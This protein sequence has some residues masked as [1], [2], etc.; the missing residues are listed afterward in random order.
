MEHVSSPARQKSSNFSP[1]ERLH[2]SRSVWAPIILSVALIACAHKQLMAQPSQI[3][4]PVDTRAQVKA[5]LGAYENAASPEQWRRLG[6]SAI[7]ILESIAVDTN[8]LPTSRA[9]SLDGLAALGT[10]ELTMRHLAGSAGERLIV[11]MSAVRGLGQVISESPLMDALRPLLQDSQAQLRGIAAETLSQTPAGCAEVKNMMAQENEAWRSRF[12]RR[13]AA[14]TASTGQSA[15][16]GPAVG[17]DPTARVV[18]YQIADPSGTIIYRYS[19]PSNIAKIEPSTYPG[20]F[21]VLLPN[22]PTVPFLSGAWTFNLLATKP[23]T[24][25]VQALI[26]TPSTA[27]LTAGRL[28]AN[29]FFVGVP[30]LSARSAQMDPNFQTLLSK[31]RNIYAQIGVE[32]ADLTYI[33]VTGPDAVRFADVSFTDLST[34]YQLSSYP[35]ARDGAI[36]LFLVHSITGGSTLPGF[37]ILGESGGIPGVPV[38]GTA[39]SGVVVTMADFPNGL[40]DM[41]FVMAHETGHWL[42]LFHTTESSGSS[43]DPLPDTPECHTAPLLALP[44]YCINFGAANLMFWTFDVNP[45]PLLTRDQQFVV[46]RNPLVSQRANPALG[47]DVRSIRLGSVPVSATQLINPITVNVPGDAVSLD[48]VGVVPSVPSAQPAIR[49]PEDFPTIQLAVN[50]ANA[51]DT[52]RVGPGR[53]CGAGITKTLNLVGEGEATIMGC[54]PRSPGPVGNKTKYGF[55]IYAAASGTSISHFVFDGNGLSDTNRIPLSV[56]IVS[57][58]G[59]DNVVIDSNTFQGGAFGVL[60][61]GGN[62]Y[63]VTHNIFDGF[64]VLSNGFGGAAILTFGG[65]RVTGHSILYNRIASTVPSGNYSFLSAVNEAD[66]PLAGIAVSAQNG[67]VISNN[68]I[69]ITAN[70]NGDAGVGI[71]ATDNFTGLTTINMAIVNNDGRGSAYGLIITNDLSGGTGNS[72]GA[73]IRGNFGVNLINGSTSNVRNRSS[74]LLCDPDTGSC[75]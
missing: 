5:L 15:V 55:Y 12:A 24:V 25:D 66:V 54:P 73:T 10:G 48:L 34:L 32:L 75:P 56:G 35:K 64:T 74:L 23:T 45:S 11:R 36:N 14:Q 1:K 68:K 22:S 39:G 37:V 13:C 19:N 57:F 33:D 59:A 51:G 18:V 29:L 17:A 63:Q 26:K 31:V 47:A 27:T 61:Y 21:S 58:A 62:N 20:S 50:N 49:V 4:S 28:N 3:S 9:R 53:W 40:D 41:A 70:S 43:F 38:K 44:Q 71:L 2:R 42:G 6:D 67:T 7:P 65:S 69:S 8:A 60:I 46:M 72:V 30:G 52:I 16:S